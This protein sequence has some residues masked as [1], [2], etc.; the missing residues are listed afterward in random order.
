[1]SAHS[2]RY[3]RWADPLAACRAALAC[4]HLTL[5]QRFW[6]F[7]RRRFHHATVN[8]LIDAGEAVRIGEHVV[9]WRPA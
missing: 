7:G 6:M 4:G 2:D 8:A 5:G 3:P 1:M 9:A